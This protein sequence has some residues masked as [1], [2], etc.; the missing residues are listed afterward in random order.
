MPSNADSPSP[1]EPSPLAD[2]I[3]RLLRDAEALLLQELTLARAEI[4]ETMGRLVG[5]GVLL[6]A[7]IAIGLCGGL[8][9]AAALVLLLGEIMPKWLACALVGAFVAALGGALALYGRHLLAKAVLVPR[10]TLRSL[11][12]TGQW[13]SEELT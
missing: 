12:E 11:Q 9:L 3:A 7:G 4:G 8:A 2:L 1:N 5:G 10:R 6:L 13:M